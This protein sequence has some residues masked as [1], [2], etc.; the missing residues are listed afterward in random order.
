MALADAVAG[1]IRPAQV[2]TWTRADDTAEDLTGAT[3]TGF[4]RNHETDVTRA[5]AGTLAVTTAASGIFTWTYVAADVADAGLHD[6]QIV[7]TFASG[8]TPAKTFTGQWRVRAAL[9]V[10]A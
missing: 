8:L 7:A 6:V 9:A 4:I 3:L 10:S 2:I 5:I 1:A